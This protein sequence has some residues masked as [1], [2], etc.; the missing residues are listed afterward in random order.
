M[1][2]M[3]LMGFGENTSVLDFVMEQIRGE[4]SL[5]P[6]VAFYSQTSHTSFQEHFYASAACNNLKKY[7]DTESNHKEVLHSHTV[8][9]SK[10]DCRKVTGHF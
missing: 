9:H 5:Q 4:V 8:T 6:P 3:A 10:L 2:S 7:V 1:C